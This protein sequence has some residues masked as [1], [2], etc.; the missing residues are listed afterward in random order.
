M[1]ITSLN[2][3]AP[4][5][6]NMQNEEKRTLLILIISNLLLTVDRHLI[7]VDLT[8]DIRKHLKDYGVRRFSL[9]ILWK[10]CLFTLEFGPE[11]LI[12]P[13]DPISGKMAINNSHCPFFNHNSMDSNS[14]LLPTA[15]CP[16]FSILA[17]FPF[18]LV[19]FP[20]EDTFMPMVPSA[21]WIS[22]LPKNDVIV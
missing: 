11:A 8:E 7:P 16:I 21:F 13:V 2:T 5:T 18:P 9:L 19:A 14:L 22:R 10:N 6:T 4:L 1:K 15:P 12:F 3:L 20:V 17:P